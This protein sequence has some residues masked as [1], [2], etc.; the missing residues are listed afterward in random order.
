MSEL[1]ETLVMSELSDVL[2]ISTSEPSVPSVALA[3]GVCVEHGMF[4]APVAVLTLTGL[5]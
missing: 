3:I 5:A 1:S 4:T 2:A